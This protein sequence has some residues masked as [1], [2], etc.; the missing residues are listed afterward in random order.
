MR[1][2]RVALMLLGLAVA[3]SAGAEPEPAPVPK[4]VEKVPANPVPVL[5]GAPNMSPLSFSTR[6]AVF[7]GEV[8]ID[9]RGATLG[10]HELGPFREAGRG[11]C[12]EKGCAAID[13]DPV[14][15]PEGLRVLRFVV[16]LPYE[17]IYTAL[18]VIPYG[19]KER[20]VHHVQVTRART[21]TAPML[22]SPEAVTIRTGGG[23]TIPFTLTRDGS[24]GA[25]S[26]F[27]PQLVQLVRQ[28]GMSVSQS[29]TWNDPCSAETGCRLDGQDNVHS[30][31]LPDI[32]VGVFTGTVRVITRAGAY[33]HATLRI[34]VKR[35]IWL[36]GLLVLLGVILAGAL[37]YCVIRGRAKSKETLLL[38]RLKREIVQR[39]EGRSSRLQR[40][41]LNQV[42]AI[43]KMNV[44]D[45]TTA[46][47]LVRDAL[48]T[49]E[50]TFRVLEL[51][52]RVNAIEQVADRGIVEGLFAS[53]SRMAHGA[54]VEDLQPMGAVDGLAWEAHRVLQLAEAAA[55]IRANLTRLG[56]FHSLTVNWFDVVW[57]SDWLKTMARAALKRAVD[58]LLVPTLVRNGE[59]TVASIARLNTHYEGQ[60]RAGDAFSRHLRNLHPRTAAIDALAAQRHRDLDQAKRKGD[61]GLIRSVEAESTSFQEA[62][63]QALDG[64]RDALW[65][66]LDEFEAGPKGG[67]RQGNDA[68][69]ASTSLLPP[70]VDPDDL[71]IGVPQADDFSGLDQDIYRV[72]T[73]GIVREVFVFT[74]LAAISTTLGMMILYVPA[75]SWGTVP[76]IVLA[77]LWGFGV[78]GATLSSLQ[79]IE[80][81]FA[82]TAP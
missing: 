36:C 75:D 66:L 52:G 74:T 64:N 73:W 25:T 39:I 16:T 53:L 41:L 4:A 68:D 42:D 76:D 9:T 8:T 55:H 29:G 15:R 72:E 48:N 58:P 63:E 65:D 56:E 28:D 18:L 30:L 21:R 77:L 60:K 50:L 19:D 3:S 7:H 57:R 20:L 38:L 17:G 51:K 5:I 67:R 32:G 54:A 31:T 69:V 24:G 59:K 22:V 44:S 79:K 34:L 49:V 70:A 2:D 27:T 14:D 37:E 12:E 10:Q 23:A 35:S 13:L 62:F 61:S 78:Q 81:R 1:M 6:D 45:S 33:R 47:Q 11:A 82:G 43:G 80:A 46:V 71:P 40:E 26:Y